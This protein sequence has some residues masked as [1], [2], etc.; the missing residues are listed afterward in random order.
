MSDLEK[1]TSSSMRGQK[2]GIYEHSQCKLIIKAIDSNDPLVKIYAIC[3]AA[4]LSE[5]KDKLDLDTIKICNDVCVSLQNTF[6]T[7]TKSGEYYNIAWMFP[8]SEETYDKYIMPWHKTSL[9]F[10]PLKTNYRNRK[11]PLSRKRVNV[12]PYAQ[13]DYHNEFVEFE[14]RLQKKIDE[15]LSKLTDAFCFFTTT[16]AL[17][18][19][20]YNILKGE[21]ATWALAELSDIRRELTKEISPNVWKEF[22][23]PTETEQG[24][25]DHGD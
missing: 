2:K 9:E 20:S 12:S 21:Y 1:F 4:Q 25:E 16:S 24:Q 15:D 10:Y 13:I 17:S 23:K 11:Y 14:D 18:D 8:P 6:P 7:K 22:N 19:R 5:K 3:E